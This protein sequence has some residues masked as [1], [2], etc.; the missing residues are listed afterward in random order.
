[1]SVTSIV[2]H[3]LAECVV[4]EQVLRAPMQ[5][6]SSTWGGALLERPYRWAVALDPATLWFGVEFPKDRPDPARFE[7]GA[8]VEWL[9]QQGDVAELFLMSESGQYQEFHIT[10]DGAWWAMTFS[11]YRRRETQPV[12]PERVVCF[13]ETGEG[14]WR[15]VL[16]IPRSDIA[17]SLT[18]GVRAQVSACLHESEGVRYVSSAGT[19]SYEADFHD[20]RSFQP[21][22]LG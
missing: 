7:R 20:G 3:R 8:F 4:P 22:V 21:V 16:G 15:G 6:V 12:R 9:A 17:I 18:E 19:P 2:I 11:G 5:Q 14:V 1:M 10:G 13:V